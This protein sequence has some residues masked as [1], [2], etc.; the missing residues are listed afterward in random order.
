MRRLI[1]LIF[2]VSFLLIFLPQKPYCHAA[3]QQYKL[4]WEHLNS[5]VKECNLDTQSLHILKKISE[6][7]NKSAYGG[8]T[9][10]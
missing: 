8:I 3:D 1:Y 5:Y 7:K 6:S 9:I 10:T 4:E 2:A